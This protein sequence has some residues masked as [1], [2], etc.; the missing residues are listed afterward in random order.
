MAIFESSDKNSVK[1]YHVRRI[2]VRSGTKKEYNSWLRAP[3]HPKKDVVWVDFGFRKKFAVKT[4]F[5]ESLT[6]FLTGMSI[7]E[8]AIVSV[9]WSCVADEPITVPANVS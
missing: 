8:A 1:E 4:S 6:F 5:R 2:M 9:Q 3:E 7:F